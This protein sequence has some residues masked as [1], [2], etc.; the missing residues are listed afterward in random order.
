MIMTAFAGGLL[1]GAAG[2][3]ALLR[4]RQSDDAAM[5]DKFKAIAADTL[6]ANNE[7][8][9]QLAESRL[10]QSEQSATSTLDKRPRRLMK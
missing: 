5:I 3:W 4:A 9:L 8:F 6:R 7:S 1:L 2:A 10:K